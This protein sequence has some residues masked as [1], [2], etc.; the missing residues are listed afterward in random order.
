MVDFALEGNGDGL[1]AAMRMSS[2][3]TSFGSGLK[4]PRTSVVEHEEGG[5]VVGECE[6]VEDGLNEEGVA[7]PV[8][9]RGRNEGLYLLARES[10]HRVADLTHAV[11]DTTLLP[12]LG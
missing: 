2:H 5:D 10:H 7:H 9:G 12:R 1:K 3:A 4:L 6:S 8:R 11:T